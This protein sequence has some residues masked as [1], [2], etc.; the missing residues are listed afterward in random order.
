MCWEGQEGPGLIIQVILAHG[1]AQ[2]VGPYS[3]G[4]W[5][6]LCLLDG[7]RLLCDPG[8]GTRGLWASVA[9]LYDGIT[10]TTQ[11]CQTIQ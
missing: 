7:P 4:V 2:E 1:G 5:S 10:S 6:A 11:G 8:P 3:T 9:S